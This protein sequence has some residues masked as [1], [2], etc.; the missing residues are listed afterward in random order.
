MALLTTHVGSLPRG[1]EL[2][3]LIFAKDRGDNYDKERF[4]QVVRDSVSA[5]IKRQKEVGI[6]IPSDGEMSK[7]SYATYIGE[8]LSGFGGDSPRNPPADLEDYP[9][10]LK[11]LAAAG[12][13]PTYKRP[14]CVGPVKVKDLE[15]LRKDIK[16][17]QDAMQ[18]HGYKQGFMNSASPGVISMFQPSEYHKSPDDYLQD[19]AEAM[20]EEYR[21]IV[22][23]GLDLQIDSPDLALGRHII[24]KDKSDKE[25][26]ARAEKHLEALNYALA[27]LP[28]DKL[29]LH[30]CWGNYEGPHH[31][32]IDMHKIMPLVLAKARPNILLFESANP[33]HMHEINQWEGGALKPRDEHILVPG[34]IDT[35][36][37]FIEH[38]DLVKERAQRWIKLFGTDRLI[39][40]TDCGFA[41]FAGFGAVD[42]EIAYSKLRVLVDGCKLAA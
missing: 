16:N 5:T 15:P 4:D 11:K 32:D 22:E 36:T 17:M 23:S 13:T 1:E 25:F 24:Y 28:A 20:R 26:L 19:L 34:L 41:T 18:E 39:F 14:M 9:S 7:I 33:R 31:C 42:G 12:G 40:G 6:S 10:F 37:N 21:M 27:G 8:R 2:T 3:E 29:R 38:P 30:I 35:T